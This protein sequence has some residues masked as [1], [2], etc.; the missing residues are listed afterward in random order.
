MKVH[1]V[2]IAKMCHNTNMTICQITGDNSQTV[3]ED[4]EPW[5]RDS[6]VDGVVYRLENP[7]TTP[8]DQHNA[9]MQSK[10]ADGW[11][12]GEVK[13]AS[14]KRHPALVPYDQLPAEQKIKDVLF[15]NVVDALKPYLPTAAAPEDDMPDG[16]TI[17]DGG[18]PAVGSGTPAPAATGGATQTQESENPPAPTPD[19]GTQLQNNTAPAQETSTEQPTETAAPT[20]FIID[21]AF[22]DANPAAVNAGFK[23]GDSVTQDA[24]GNITAASVAE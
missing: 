16:A 19:S 5:Q 7:N 22:L 3:W 6:A 17:K 15:Q 24:E 11:V 1:V 13:D 21:Q 2:D 12:Y 23:V 14:L 9:W 20:P 18:T 8:E 10:I 4:A